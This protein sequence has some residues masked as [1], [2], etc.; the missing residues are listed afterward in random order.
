MF[1]YQRN[2]FIKLLRI[3]LQLNPFN[4]LC[5]GDCVVQVKVRPFA[6]YMK[7]VNYSCKFRIFQ[8]RLTI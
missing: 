7:K 8:L 5:I 3:G 6:I 2:I 1:A 4:F